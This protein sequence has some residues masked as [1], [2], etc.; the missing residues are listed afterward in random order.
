MNDNMKIWDAVEKSDT[1]YTKADDTG[2]NRGMTSIN[3]VYL[4]KRATEIFGSIGIG[5]GF[6]ILEERLDDCFVITTKDNGEVMT[7]THTIKIELW[8][9]QGA[10]IGKLVNFG[11]TKYIYKSKYGVTVDEEAPKK[12]LTDAIKK[13]LSMLGF[14]A[15]IHMGEFEDREYLAERQRESALSHAED[16]DLE[17]AAQEKEF[18]DWVIQELKVYDQIDTLKNLKVIYDLHTNK[19]VR[20]HSK[21]AEAAFNKAYEARKSIIINGDKK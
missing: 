14:C 10:E 18:N 7:K 15:D 1:K 11:H 6:N 20:R 17:K 12:S 8:Y 9:K 2:A 4:M 16:K 3:G 13:C 19:A 21:A 5:W